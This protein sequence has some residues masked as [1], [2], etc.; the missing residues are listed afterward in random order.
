[1][2][3]N[4]NTVLYPPMAPGGAQWPPHAG[5]T[6][7]LLGNAVVVEYSAQ[8]MDHCKI[9]D[10]KLTL[11]IP[12]HAKGHP[13]AEYI[14]C[15]DTVKD[16]MLARGYITHNSQFQ[17]AEL[18]QILGGKR[19]LKPAYDELAMAF[20]VNNIPSMQEIDKAVLQLVKDCGKK[21]AQTIKTSKKVPPSPG[22]PVGKSL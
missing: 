11:G 16:Q 13:L 20:A 22:I 15:Q 17:E 18:Q 12:H 4:I 3:Q 9:S 19:R 2:V 7:H 8:L 21:L 1:M 10:H 5:Q 6:S 14:M